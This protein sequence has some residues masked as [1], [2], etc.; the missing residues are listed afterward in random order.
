MQ[1]GR[2]T[3][4]HGSGDGCDA[5]E[6]DWPRRVL[7]LQQQPP[8][9]PSNPTGGKEGFCPRTLEG[10]LVL[11]PWFRTSGL[12]NYERFLLEVLSP[13]VC[14]VVTAAAGNKHRCPKGLTSPTN[15]VM[16]T[17]VSGDTPSLPGLLHEWKLPGDSRWGWGPVADFQTGSQNRQ[18]LC[19]LT[20]SA[21]VLGT[22]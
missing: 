4:D 20:V 18:G 13:P 6:M 5:V 16:D 19:L 10:S 7:D 9:V 17:D 2:G 22:Q 15:Q 3:R 8:H 21:P 11:P 12:L 14:G 1:K